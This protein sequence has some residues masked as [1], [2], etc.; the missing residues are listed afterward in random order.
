MGFMSFMGYP[1][2]L[3]AVACFL[4]LRL[5]SRNVGLPVNWPLVGMLPGLLLN[6]HSI[7]DLC[8]QVLERSGFTFEFKG[9]W[10]ANMDM[11]S[12]SDPA[13]VHY[14]M[15]TNFSNFPKGSRFKK[16]FDVFGDGIF[17]SDSDLWKT[18]RKTAHALINHQ[19]FHRF[20]V[21][22]TA[23]KLEKGLIPVLE[24]VSGLSLV[25]DLQD[26]FQR[27][28]F[29]TTCMLVTGYDPGC[30]SIEFP[31]VPFAKAL[32]DA[33]EALFFR[34]IVPE[35]CWKLQRWLGIGEEK[36]LNRAWRTL[37]HFI[38]NYIAKKREELSKTTTSMKEE[39]D[40]ADLLTSYMEEGEMGGS[41]SD[42]FLRDTILNF[43]VAGRDTTSTALTWFFWLISKHPVVEAK[44][45]KEVRAKESEKWRLFDTEEL[46]GMVYLHGA[47]C[48]SLRLFPP[49]PFQH[50]VPLSPD[51][52]PSGHKVNPEKKIL[53]SLF[54]MGRMEGIWGKDCLEFKPERWISE[55]GGIR[56]EP[57]YKFF[58]FN[59]GPRTCIGK[60]VA[61]T[62]MKAV[63]AAMIYNYH[64]QL[65]EYHPVIP[66]ISIIL[67]MK[68][69]MKVRVSKRSIQHSDE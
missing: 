35:S 32:D 26:V 62:Q 56:Y 44:I 5:L 15:S 41:K 55:R 38:A 22:T 16:I 18:Q 64:V 60:E 69:G 33:E 65:E 57:S 31:D 23:V 68:H 17:N 48:E 49:V 21:K 46:S 12:T 42:K 67:H 36:K 2:I 50:K 8:T 47:L 7:H 34:H 51:I 28:T 25:V 40:G 4:F 9:P 6:I 52:L 20:F 45:L 29:D 13:N 14:I 53:V 27:F 63:A 54:A 24:H 1:E 30:L 66:N 19:R 59:A 11:V 43:I 39:R 37:D 3:L 10:F 61:F 58:A